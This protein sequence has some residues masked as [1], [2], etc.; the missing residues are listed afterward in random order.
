[1]CRLELRLS[2]FV[3]PGHYGDFCCLLRRFMRWEIS[4]VVIEAIWSW[5][6]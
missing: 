2:P 3:S 1:L 5:V 6:M 4:S